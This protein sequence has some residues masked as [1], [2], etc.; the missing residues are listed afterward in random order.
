L[1]RLQDTKIEGVRRRVTW[2]KMDH[3]IGFMAALPSL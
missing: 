2:L 3:R 1:K